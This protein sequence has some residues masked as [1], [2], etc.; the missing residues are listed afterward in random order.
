M[1]EEE[2]VSPFKTAEKDIADRNNFGVQDVFGTGGDAMCICEEIIWAFRR[3][4]ENF[5]FCSPLGLI[6]VLY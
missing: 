5:D 4:R 3:K 6:I 1:G 2:S